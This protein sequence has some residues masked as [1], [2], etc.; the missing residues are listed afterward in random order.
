[1]SFRPIILPSCLCI[2]GF[3]TMCMGGGGVLGLT[4]DA[5]HFNVLR[6][7]Q[8]SLQ[9]KSCILTCSFQWKWRN[10]H[11]NRSLMKCLSRL[12]LVI[13][14]INDLEIYLDTPLLIALTQHNQKFTLDFK[15]FINSSMKDLVNKCC[16]IHLKI[17]KHS[18][19]LLRSVTA[20]LAFCSL[21]H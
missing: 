19:K 18:T 10:P 8:S 4:E 5:A 14:I 7:I 13:P 11:K 16:Q 17:F 1:M 6:K 3:I 2:R 20:S 21:L 15:S 12:L 9:N